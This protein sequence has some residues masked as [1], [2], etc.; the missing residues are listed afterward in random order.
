MKFIYFIL[1]LFFFTCSCKE[2]KPIEIYRM[3]KL[4]HYGTLQFY[5]IYNH[6]GK[7]ENELINSVIDYNRATISIDTILKYRFFCRIF[8]LKDKVLTKDFKEGGEESIMDYADKR[9]VDIA[10]DNKGKDKYKC[11]VYYSIRHK[12]TAPV[13]EYWWEAP[14]QLEQLLNPIPKRS[15]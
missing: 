14:Q 3:N 10:W 1:F 9:F 11:R 4:N 13:M 8:Y 7:S 5:V 15:L 6:R 12:R 2:D